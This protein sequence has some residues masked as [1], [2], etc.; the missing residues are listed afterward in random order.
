MVKGLGVNRLGFKVGLGGLVPR[1]FSRLM[2]F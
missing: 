2:G 1:G